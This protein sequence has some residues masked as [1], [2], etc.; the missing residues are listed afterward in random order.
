[1]NLQIKFGPVY[2]PWSNGINERN[3]YSADIVVRKVM[4]TD[5]KLGLQKAVNLAAWTHNTN[6]NILRY[7]PMRLITGKSVNIPG[8]T[9]G[10]DATE[11]LFDSEAVQKIMERHHEFIKKFREVEYSEK[12]KK[13]ARARSGVMNNHFYRDGDEVFYEEKDKAAW[14]HI[15]IEYT[16]A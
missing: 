7:K 8:I 14:L 15:C 1:M 16:C 2:S 13:P 9:V 12:L 4:E 3:H 5:K 10:N 11:A 6:I